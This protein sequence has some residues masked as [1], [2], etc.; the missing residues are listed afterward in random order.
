MPRRPSECDGGPAREL[1]GRA[2]R[3]GG[4]TPLA[5]R[6]ALLGHHT[7]EDASHAQVDHAA[8]GQALNDMVSADCADPVP[9]V[10]QPV[11]GQIG[12]TDTVVGHVHDQ[13]P[14]LL[15]RGHGRPR[16]S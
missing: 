14:T 3:R 8:Q 16:G 6:A 13:R 9:Q 1:E 5:L 2:A 12:A 11:S 4:A 10:A 7:L 15:A